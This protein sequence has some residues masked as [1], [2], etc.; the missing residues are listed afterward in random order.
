[1]LHLGRR[2]TSKFAI[3]LHGIEAS[4]IADVAKECMGLDIPFVSV[5]DGMLVPVDE[6]EMVRVFFNKVLTERFGFAPEPSIETT[7][8]YDMQLEVC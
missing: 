4:I 1:V 2:G 6:S 5:F 8:G 3:K 7:A